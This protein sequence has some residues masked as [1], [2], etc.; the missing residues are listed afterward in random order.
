MK[1]LFLGYSSLFQRKIYPSLKK[2]KNISVEVA[3]LKKKK[4]LNNIFFYDSYKVA[5]DNSDAKVVYISLINSEHFKWA[6]YCLKKNKH[7]IIDKPITLNFNQTKKLIKIAKNKK[8]FLSEAVVFHYHNQFK[9][10]YSFLNFK[11]KIELKAFFHI[12]KLSKNN[13][14]NH[15]LL[16]GGCFNDM[17]T[18]AAFLI[19]NFFKRKNFYLKKK[20]VTRKFY[21]FELSIYSHLL[22]CDFSFKFNS[23]YKNEIILT[24]NNKT[25]LI[26]FAFSP[27]IN[28]ATYI[29]IFDH[30][31]NKEY[32]IY[33][34]KQNVFDDYFRFIFKLIK[35][36]RYNYYYNEIEK[37]AK[38]KKKIS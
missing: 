6:I 38:T 29:S 18:Y 26:K 35:N 34:K 25:Y 17:S 3:S 14:R 4:K 11:K 30:L 20:K 8:L 5:V 32:K 21:N 1:I 24:N 7:L 31:T 37:I 2:F 16:G 10:V 12:P 33:L 27:P 9:K 28:K 15:K 23:E 22:V 13:F 19:N 36:K